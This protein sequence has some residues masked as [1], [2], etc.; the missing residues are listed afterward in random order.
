MKSD[1]HRGTPSAFGYLSPADYEQ[2]FAPTTLS[3]VA[4]SPVSTSRGN[5]RPRG[6]PEAAP[7]GCGDVAHGVVRPEW[8]AVR[9]NAQ[10]VI[11]KTARWG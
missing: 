5:L 7:D 8:N 3:Q 10:L 6:Y 1:N 2:T 9:H 11:V 4:A